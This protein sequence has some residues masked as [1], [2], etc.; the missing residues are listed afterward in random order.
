ML[1]PVGT[2]IMLLLL[3]II[4]V[5]QVHPVLRVVSGHTAFVPPP[6]TTPVQLQPPPDKTA[7]ML[8]NLRNNLPVKHL[9]VVVGGGEG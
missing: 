1:T 2:E 5:Y 9:V 7:V 3:A 6:V 8:L 4:I